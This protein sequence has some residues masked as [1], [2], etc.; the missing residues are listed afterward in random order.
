MDKNFKPENKTGNPATDI[1]SLR[2]ELAEKV[3]INLEKHKKEI[4]D[5]S[6]MT[7]SKKANGGFPTNENLPPVQYSSS[8]DSEYEFYGLPRERG[9]L[10][11]RKSG[12]VMDTKN[13][14]YTFVGP[15]GRALHTPDR[16]GNGLFITLKGEQ[17]KR[18][19]DEL[20][21]SIKNLVDT[22]VP[23]E[24]GDKYEDMKNILKEA[25]PVLEAFGNISQQFPSNGKISVRSLIEECKEMLIDLDTSERPV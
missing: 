2:L 3:K 18:L 4:K 12:Y 6:L 10:Q 22:L 21:D 13:N 14:L 15:L 9:Y 17:G 23:Y 7:T 5:F 25:L 19:P 16:P 1:E 20:V 24:E 8:Y 11:E